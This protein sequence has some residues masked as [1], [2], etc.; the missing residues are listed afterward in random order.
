MQWQQ[1]RGGLALALPP[2][3]KW[4]V[5]LFRDLI[6]KY[7]VNN[8][9]CIPPIRTDGQTH[10]SWPRLVFAFCLRWKIV[11]VSTILLIYFLLFVSCKFQRQNLHLGRIRSTENIEIVKEKRKIP[12]AKYVLQ[13]RGECFNDF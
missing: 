13:I 8:R 9:I 2:N 4:F 11:F 3:A 1:Q 5:C 12:V 10:L 7:T 6:S